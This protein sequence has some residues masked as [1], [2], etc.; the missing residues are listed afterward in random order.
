MLGVPQVDH[1]KGVL[2]T[3]RDRQRQN[4]SE[5][6]E[7]RR[8]VLIVRRK[9]EARSGGGAHKLCTAISRRVS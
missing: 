8:E 7:A 5:G 3:G 2:C 6:W 1:E 4:E 9:E